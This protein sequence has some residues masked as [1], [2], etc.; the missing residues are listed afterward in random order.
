MQETALATARQCEP[1]DPAGIG[2]WLYRVAVRQSL[3]YRRRVGRY[4]RR[5]ERFAN[6]SPTC[7]GDEQTL[8]IPERLVIASEQR[9]LVNAALE[10]LHRGD[11]EIL[12]LKYIENWSCRQIADHL[13]ISE[14]AVK[15]RLLRARNALRRE[16]LRI[17]EDWVVP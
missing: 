9:R 5:I 10:T 11:C 1:D 7:G 15:S 14:S 3:L 4:A 8:A 2:R 6:I 13:G 16:L 12:L 17:N